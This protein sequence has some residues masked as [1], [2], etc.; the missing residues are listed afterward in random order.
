M[1]IGPAG[2]RRYYTTPAVGLPAELIKYTII[3]P[4]LPSFLQGA[5]CPKFWSKFRP[6]SSSDCRIFERGRSIGKQ[7]QTCQRPMIGLSS[8]QTWVG[9][10]PPTPRTVLKV[11]WQGKS[12]KYALIIPTVTTGYLPQSRDL[13][14]S[15][16]AKA[17]D[18]DRADWRF[19]TEHIFVNK[20][21]YSMLLAKKCW[22]NTLCC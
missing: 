1:R 17:Q 10:V 6:Q 14:R 13:C 4:M 15:V 2:A 7:K 21:T 18:C 16:A 8:Y 9:W 19:L 3:R 11:I 12:V 5:K 20:M 22:I